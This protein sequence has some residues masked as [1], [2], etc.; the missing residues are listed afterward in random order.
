MQPSHEALLRNKLRLPPDVKLA[1][2]D[3][4]I[5]EKSYGKLLVYLGKWRRF[6]LG[7]RG[8]LSIMGNFPQI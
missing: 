2:A 3:I 6:L 7:K 5:S 4:L 8:F 1:A